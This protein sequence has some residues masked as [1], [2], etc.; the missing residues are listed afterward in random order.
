MELALSSM[1]AASVAESGIPAGD[2]DCD[3]NVVDA[4]GE[5]GGCGLD[6]DS[7]GICDDTDN[8]TDTTACN[9]DDA[10]NASCASVDEC[11]VC[12]G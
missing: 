11:G 1:S 12:G 3:G 5:C 8:C 7:D 10:A 2:C 4:C 9:F 6:I